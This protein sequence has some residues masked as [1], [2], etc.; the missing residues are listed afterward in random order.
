MG[1]IV[2]AIDKHGE[3]AVSLVLLMLKQLTHRG[4]DVFHVATPTSI[5]KG[6]FLSQLETKKCVSKTAVGQ[7]PSPVFSREKHQPIILE[8]N[9]TFVFEGH[10]YPPSKTSDA[11]E[12]AQCLKLGFQ[13][14][15]RSIVRKFDGSY[16]F[17]IASPDRI[18]ACRDLFGTIPLFY[19]ENEMYCA[20]ASERKALWMLGITNVKSFPPGNVAVISVKGFDFKPAATVTQPQQRRIGMEKAANRLQSLLLKST[21]ER[22]SDLED[23]AV[24]FSGGL[25]SSVLAVLAKTCTKNV[26]LVT[27]GLKGQPELLHAQKAAESL[28]LPLHLH[29]YRVVDVEKALEKV[30]WL[31]EEPD[32]MKV[33]VALPFFWAAETASRIGC[34]VLLAGQGADE[35]FGGYHR[36]LTDYNRG[37]VKAVQESMFHDLTTSYE[38][39]FQRDNPVC[40]FYK[41]ELRLPYIDRE[42]VQFALSLPLD[43]KI[44]S[45]DD[46]LRK[47]VLRQVAKN[48]GIPEIIVERTKKAVQYATGVDKAL[49]ELAR[50][51]GLS[52]HDYLKQVFGK[53]YPNWKG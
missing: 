31:I 2:A 27:V 52:R 38:T 24:A 21:S 28:K 19:G 46:Q 32:V 40:A 50:R 29:T 13:T 42:V 39:N 14:G 22:V 18:L 7:Y 30:L 49:R 51:R 3:E 48:L 12:V 4:A 1:A 11:Q 44:Q 33:G 34:H 53:I 10:L 9:C 47:R 6:K 20:L 26:N 45:V 43:L 23:V 15:A 25:D 5:M 16:A 35:L 8:K 17:A 36:Y 41:V 37:G